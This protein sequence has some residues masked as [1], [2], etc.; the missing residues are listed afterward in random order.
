MLGGGQLH[1]VNLPI[2]GA[3]ESTSSGAS[4]SGRE[5]GDKVDELGRL[6]NLELETLPDQCERQP[7]Q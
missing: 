4:Q 5:V 2:T 6:V 1:P 3:T 7:L